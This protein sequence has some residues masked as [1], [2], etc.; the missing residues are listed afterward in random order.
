MT[1]SFDALVIGGEAD[2]LV[3]A[4]T[5]AGAGTKVL[6]VDAADAPGGA[7]RDIEFAPGYRAAP[8]APSHDRTLI[9][10]DGGAPL[11]LD[12]SP[13]AAEQ[14]ADGLQRHSS[15]DAAR[16][17]TFARRMHSLTGFLAE[18][19]RSPPPRIEADSWSEFFA[20][21]NLARRFRQLGRTGMIEL[22]RTLPVPIA[23][24]LD[25]EFELPALKGALAALAVTDVAQGPMAAG[26]TFTFLHRQVCANDEALKA[27]AGAFIK[28]LEARA[29]AAGVTIEMKAKVR[30]LTVR[31]GHVV[32]A[33]IG[34][35]ADYAST[36]E[37]ACRTAISSLDPYTSLLDLV[38]P[39]HH[40]PEFI[41]AV[42][43][44]RFRGVS[45]RIL[46][47]L[48]ALPA[49]PD[50]SSLAGSLCIAPSMR[51]VENAYNAAKYGRCSDEPFIEIRFPTLARPE[52]AP[53][54][55]HVAVLHVQY[56]P[57]HLREGTWDALCG[58]VADRAIAQVERH[59]PGF[60]TRIRARLVLTP[61]DLESRFGVREGAPT[62]GEM[63]LDQ[64]LFM[65]PVPAAARYATP[66][67]GY[68]LCGA[69]T[70]PGAGVYGTS[71]RL[72]ARAALDA[73]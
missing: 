25:D 23:D 63:M 48:D 38:D 2:A 13:Q 41:H 61:R 31:D 29:R 30:A 35:G 53:A 14:T 49:V 19:Y 47:A 16:W 8:L 6:M 68:Y 22:L 57:Y 9:A 5:L 45:S 59:L 42:R 73:R 27:G 58:A 33:S 21:A 17:P 10:L 54:G 56:T 37:V 28:E 36:E 1:R 50:V 39:K 15:H 60:A 4:T 62:Q 69:G 67:G 3:A 11:A 51:H 43:N 44:I 55:K 12:L 52:L 20:F 46:L 72:A 24:L 65:R 40:D 32:G 64:I 26:T 71:G 7:L 34:T 18:L 66:I 70:H